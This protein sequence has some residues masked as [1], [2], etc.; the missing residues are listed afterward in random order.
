MMAA[1]ACTHHDDGLHRWRWEVGRWSGQP[2]YR[3]WCGVAVITWGDDDD[4]AY[5][6]ALGGEVTA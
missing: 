5:L 1:A 2:A 6:A 4:A 3:C